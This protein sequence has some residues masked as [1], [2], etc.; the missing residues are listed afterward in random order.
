MPTTLPVP[1]KGALRTLRNLALGTS[2]TV[3]FSAGLLTEDRRRR[4]NAA[5]EIHDNAKKLKSSR[6]YHSS[7][8]AAIETFEDQVT[9]YQE[10]AFW[11][12]SN[13]LKNTA[14]PTVSRPAGYKDPEASAASHTPIRHP[15]LP[16]SRCQIPPLTRVWRC[17]PVS[18]EQLPEPQNPTPNK[19]HNRQHKVAFDVT[20][21]LEE[22]PSNID[23]A[24]LRF[25]E[26]FDEG[27]PISDCGIIDT[28]ADVAVKLSIACRQQSKLEDYE[29]VFDIFLRYGPVDEDKF[30]LFRRWRFIDSLLKH[31]SSEMNS[32]LDPAKLKKAA[33]IYLTTFKQKPKVMS[34]RLETLGERL[35]A[36]TCRSGMY[37][38]TLALFT[39]LEANRSDGPMRAVDHLITATHMQGR[40]N[41]VFRY[42]EKF[43][44]RTFPDQLQFYKIGGLVIDSILTFG[45][46]DK[47]VQV[48]ITASLMAQ[49]DG[50]L[51]STTWLLR[52]LGYDWRNHRDISRTRRLFERLELLLHVTKHPQ[53]IYSAIIQF[54]IE[55]GDEASARSYYDK[56]R[57]SY[58]PIPADAR[59]YGHFAFAKAQRHDWPGVIEDFRKLKDFSPDYRDEHSASFTPIL[60]LFAQSNSVSETEDFI[61]TFVEKSGLKLTT[62]IMNIM[63]DSYAKAGELD[64]IAR[65]VAYAAEEGHAIDAV[66]FNTILNRLFRTW[67]FSFWEIW[68]F[69]LSVEKLGDVYSYLRL[70]DKDTGPILRQ[71]AISRCSDQGEITHRLRVLERLGQ[72]SDQHLDSQA[73]YQAMS[74]ALAKGDAAAS[75]KFY[76]RAET[77]QILVV[78]K[79]LVIAVKASLLLSGNQLDETTRLIWDAQRKGLDVGSSITAVFLHQIAELFEDRTHQTSHIIELAQRTISKFEEFQIDIP[80][81][82][83][84]TTASVLERRGHYRPC[85]VLWDAMSCRLNIPPSSFVLETL[86]VLLKA[87]IGLMDSN[88]IQWVVNMATANRVTPDTHFRL[89]LK[90]ARR[91]TTRLL[92]SNPY[93]EKIHQFLESIEEALR[94]TKILRSEARLEKQ[95]ANQKLLNIIGKALQ[96]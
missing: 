92:N 60:K 4:I 74:L 13:V 16:I 29:K 64:S 5:R 39:R 84:T 58:E 76:R 25:F 45:D 31:S 32:L 18:S 81:H 93:Q 69:F 33:S 21:L 57:I 36:E 56:M 38:L 72:E 94:L 19:V 23:A 85:I 65:W 86:T 27:L 9:R 67:K 34:L 71:I 75:L 15:S 37:G 88:G 52:V 54:C 59:T 12:P 79:H 30:Y 10:D 89:L 3:A 82:I 55:A 83:V 26:A 2:F 20:K 80:V 70:I 73:V 91:S 96:D 14:I 49:R 7:G 50:M 63:I 90:N 66:S 95:D 41:Y 61:R 11:L 42:F 22:V 6:N 28:L 8:T 62:H 68:N 47:A 48:L 51:L 78:S 44:S 17:W 43:Y 77:D 53:A 24:L 1:S 87:Y 40:H 46:V 35:C